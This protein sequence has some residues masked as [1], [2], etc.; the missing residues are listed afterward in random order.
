[1]A[2]R[3]P[4]AASRHV[5]GRHAARAVLARRPEAI[6][7]AA[8][9][10]GARSGALE[11]F[12]QTLAALKVPIKYLDRAALDRLASGGR[13]QGVVVEIQPLKEFTLEDFENLVLFRGDDLRLLALD[14]VEDPRNLGACLRTADA[15]GID[16]VV[17]PRSRSPMLTPVAIK[18]ATGA[19]ETVPIFR[20]ANL[21]RTLKWLRQAGVMVVGTD[22]SAERTLFEAELQSP[23]VLVLGGEG[24]GLRHLTRQTCDQLVAIPMIGTVESLN[25]SVAAGV[26]LFELVRQDRSVPDA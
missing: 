13:H 2:D 5:Y 18:A 8:L 9:L 23:L 19:A 11:T 21:V 14:G 15:A 3:S 22:S 12:E 24:R 20:S 4:S 6:L 17:V 1:V 16:A 26:A 10:A 7:G 25:V